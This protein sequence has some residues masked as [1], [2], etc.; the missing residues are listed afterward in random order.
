MLEFTANWKTVNLSGFLSLMMRPANKVC[1]L[2]GCR[3]FQTLEELGSACD[4]VSV[5][6]PTDKH[7][8]V[9]VPLD[10]S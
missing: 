8:E 7:A 4:A 5:V 3:R 1:T 9:A 6:S 2:H 10:S